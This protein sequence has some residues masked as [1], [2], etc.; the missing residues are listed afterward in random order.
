[1]QSPRRVQQESDQRL[2]AD[3]NDKPHTTALSTLTLDMG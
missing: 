3:P 2:K 1:M